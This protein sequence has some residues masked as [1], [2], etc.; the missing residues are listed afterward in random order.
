MGIALQSLPPRRTFPVIVWQGVVHL[1]IVFDLLQRSRKRV[2]ILSNE[3]KSRRGY[4]AVF[5]SVCNQPKSLPIRL[6]L[7][8]FKAVF[9]LPSLSSSCCYSCS[10]VTACSYSCSLVTACS[11]SCSLVTA[12]AAVH[13]SLQLQLFTGRCMQLQLFA[14]HC[15][16]LFTG[17]CSCS[18]SLVAAAA[19]QTC[20]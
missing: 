6:Q 18:C 16:Q 7:L 8:N 15:M 11:C 3:K 14:S 5:V 20:W 10:L 17:L 12:V 13:W 4:G 2:E 9:V 19:S 1:S